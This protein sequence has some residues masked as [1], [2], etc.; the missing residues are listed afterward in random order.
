MPT[1]IEIMYI[2]ITN[3]KYKSFFII[4]ITLGE[5]DVDASCIAK[6]LNEIAIA[7]TAAS[8]RTKVLMSVAELCKC[9]LGNVWYTIIPGEINMSVAII[10]IT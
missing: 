10:T 3:K 5:Y 8:P 4:F 9:K 1:M 6:R 7:S 2:P